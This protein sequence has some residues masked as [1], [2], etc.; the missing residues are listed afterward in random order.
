MRRRVVAALGVIAVMGS[1]LLF[2]R[3]PQVRG[4]RKDFIHPTIIIQNHPNFRT[5]GHF[6]KNE[7]IGDLFLRYTK[8]VFKPYCYGDDYSPQMLGRF[9]LYW[10][11]ESYWSNASSAHISHNSKFTGKAYPPE[12]GT[13]HIWC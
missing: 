2:V 11:K 6:C 8:N 10:K 3:P 12:S 4:E 5:D 1:S 7:E 13:H 9:V